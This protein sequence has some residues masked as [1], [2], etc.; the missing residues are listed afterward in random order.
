MWRVAVFL[1]RIYQR[2]VSPWLPPTCRFHPSC[3]S[4]AAEA[5]RRHGMLRGG[6]L[7]LR[8]VARCHPWHPG[9]VDPVPPLRTPAAADARSGRPGGA[10]RDRLLTGDPA[11]G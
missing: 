8:R 6:W 3:S 11:D 1:I 10:H 7:T 4:Y 5:L 2:L 9:G